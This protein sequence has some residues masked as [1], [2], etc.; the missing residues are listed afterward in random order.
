MVSKL[1][2][3]TEKG[4]SAS[5]QVEDYTYEQVK[6]MIEEEELAKPSVV[7][8]FELIANRCLPQEALNTLPLEEIISRAKNVTH[9][10]L[11]RERLHKLN[12]TV[13]EMPRLSHLYMQHNRLEDISMLA[14][15]SSL[16]F[17]TLAN[18]Y[19]SDVRALAG[20]TNV[21]FL[22]L[23]Y[24]MLSSTEDLVDSL[25]P[26]VVYLDVAGNPL[27]P[28]PEHDDYNEEEESLVREVLAASLPKLKQL[29]RHDISE[30]EK[31]NA[32]EAYG[33][34]IFSDEEEDTD[35]DTDEHD[36]EG[37][38]T[39]T[40]IKEEPN[41]VLDF[42]HSTPCKV[43]LPDDSAQIEAEKLKLKAIVELALDPTADANAA[44]KASMV[45]ITQSFNR[46]K[47]QKMQRSRNRI[48]LDRQ[49][50]IQSLFEMKQLRE[51]VLGSITIDR[52]RS[53]AQTL[54]SREKG[55][56]GVR[57]QTPPQP[58]SRRASS[59]GKAYIQSGSS[60]EGLPIYNHVVSNGLSSR[61]ASSGLP[62]PMSSG[63]SSRGAVPRTRAIS[64]G[65]TSSRP[66]SASSSA[67]FTARP[68]SPDGLGVRPSSGRGGNTISRPG[69]A[70]STSTMYINWKLPSSGGKGAG[71]RPSS[72][73]SGSAEC[74][75]RKLVSSHRHDDSWRS[76]GGNR[77]EN[78]L[79]P[80]Q[81]CLSSRPASPEVS[82]AVEASLIDMDSRGSMSTSQNG[83]KPPS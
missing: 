81:S 22:D 13:T 25:P 5:E 52:F 53:Y 18:N 72:G 77:L 69:S 41:T 70:G 42:E 28:A 68:P 47:D 9:V 29:N 36:E 79:A 58:L 57:C 19:I 30:E 62:R 46:S 82:D 26:S 66:A 65:T 33:V 23:S 39:E 16:R 6:Q 1:P 55:I 31:R 20:L 61:P 74:I 3:I 21:V 14:C 80:G 40:S 71:S 76:S 45:D 48:E 27:C 12:E 64:G 7:L 2:V 11:D 60:F 37:D 24:N 67:S 8:N 32:R 51:D 38:Q 34:P 56:N 78:G 43:T 4:T 73:G 10:R 44:A 83:S 35:E 63:S 50:Q 59:D 15:C 54:E 49:T 75:S 17:V